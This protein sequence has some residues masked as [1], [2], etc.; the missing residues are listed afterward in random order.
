MA[1]LVA[2]E[3]EHGEAAL[4]KAPVQRLEARV[5][6]REAA[7]AGDIDDEQRLPSE[8]VERARL[9]VDGLKRDV[10]WDTHMGSNLQPNSNR[11]GPGGAIREAS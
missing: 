4:A 1:E 2:R 5:L 10:G 7:L 11:F 9:A 8:I 3:A 6:G